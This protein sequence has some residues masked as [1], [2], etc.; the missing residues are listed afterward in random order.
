MTALRGQAQFGKPTVSDKP[1]YRGPGGM[2]MFDRA[3]VSMGSRGGAVIW[4]MRDAFMPRGTTSAERLMRLSAKQADGTITKFEAMELAQH[5]ET[6]GFAVFGRYPRGF[7]DHVLRLELMG[8][9]RRDAILHVCSGTL[10]DQERWTVDIRQE[11]RPAVRASGTALPFQDASFPAVMIDP[12]YSDQYARDLYGVENPRPS[13]LLKE[14]AR[15]VKPGGRI[16]L[17]HVAVPFPQPRCA[18]INVYGITTGVG[19][20]IRAFTLFE[21]QQAGL[22]QSVDAVDPCEGIVEG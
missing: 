19:Y 2:P 3:T 11:A 22:F 16:G 5:G 4:V 10:S 18:L 12:P 1:G 7:L 9:V 14:A 20:R 17:L 8:H 13:W 21:K 6:D 15:V